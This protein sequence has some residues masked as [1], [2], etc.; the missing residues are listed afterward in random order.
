ME[1]RITLEITSKGW[2]KT[3]KTKNTTHRIEW[4]L[5]ASGAHSVTGSLEGDTTVDDHLFD[6]LS[7]LDGYDGAR[8][9]NSLEES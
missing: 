4:V 8:Y 5:D 7:G 2:I 1:N 6:V 3:V 9:L